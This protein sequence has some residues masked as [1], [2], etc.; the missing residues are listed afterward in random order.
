MNFNVITEVFDRRYNKWSNR[1]IWFIFVLEIIAL[2]LGLW[3]DKRFNFK[4]LFPMV[5]QILAVN[6]KE[7]TCFLDVPCKLNLTENI[8]DLTMNGIIIDNKESYSRQYQF[9]ID[10]LQYS[11]VPNTNRIVLTGKVFVRVAGESS[12]KTLYEENFDNEVLELKLN[13][14]SFPSVEG[15]LN[16]MIPDKLMRR[17]DTRNE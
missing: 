5:I 8:L 17:E 11:T 6:R 13:D 12:G 16:S 14:T 10:S 2:L 4:L 9:D 15:Y 7:T 3:T 1:L